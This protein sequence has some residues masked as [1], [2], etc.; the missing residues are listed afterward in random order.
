MDSSG[1]AAPNRNPL[2]GRE[3]KCEYAMQPTPFGKHAVENS[4]ELARSKSAHFLQSSAAKEKP[5]KGSNGM[6]L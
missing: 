5:M 1:E 3:R 4:Q 6:T 2:D